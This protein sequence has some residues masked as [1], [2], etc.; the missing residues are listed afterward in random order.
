MQTGDLRANRILLLSGAWLAFLAIA[1]ES[2]SQVTLHQQPDPRAEVGR[3]A[4][5]VAAAAAHNYP[6]ETIYRL[7]RNALEENVQKGRDSDAYR[8]GAHLAAAFWIQQLPED[9]SWRE[10]ALARHRD[11]VAWLL[12]RT[13]LPEEEVAHTV[14]R[15]EGLTA[16]SEQR[17]LE[18][19]R[20]I[21]Q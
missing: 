14:A 12:P 19:L 17:L 7:I 20:G 4:T 2:R 21:R 5:T 1:P 16:T 8:V 3:G 13:G 11:I 9:V 10:T 6:P 15:A 18:F